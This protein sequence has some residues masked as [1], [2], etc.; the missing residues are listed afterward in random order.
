MSGLNKWQASRKQKHARRAFLGRGA[1]ESDIYRKQRPVQRVW[2]FSLTLSPS[3]SLCVSLLSLPLSLCVCV[4]LITG[5]LSVLPMHHSNITAV[6]HA[7]KLSQVYFVPNG[8]GTDIL[9]FGV[10]V[11]YFKRID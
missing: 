9:Y 5:V 3:L 7:S 8:V 10:L 11:Q 4:C 6:S 2:Y 1:A